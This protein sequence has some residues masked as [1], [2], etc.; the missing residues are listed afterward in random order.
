MP[1]PVQWPAALD[2]AVE[3]P[4]REQH[5]RGGPTDSQLGLNPVLTWSARTDAFE[6]TLLV[7][8]WF[9]WAVSCSTVAR[10]F[11]RTHLCSLRSPLSS[12][13]RGAPYVPRR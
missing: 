5:D 10:L 4:W 2:Y 1:T 3:D 11:A 6:D 12:I 8:P 13:A 9:I 7:A